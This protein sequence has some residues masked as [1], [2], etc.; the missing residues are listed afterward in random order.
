MIRVVTIAAALAVAAWFAL[1][2]SQSTG[3]NAARDRLADLGRPSAA[4]AQRTSDLLDRAGR[5]NPD[6]GVDLLRARLALQRGD[7]AGATRTALRVVR[8]EPANLEAWG[9]IALVNER[10]D[11]ALAARARAA[12]RRLSPPVPAP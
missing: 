3:A 11:P 6:R 1:G 2:V 9:V 7:A 10:R 4:A 5:L 12:L 8:A